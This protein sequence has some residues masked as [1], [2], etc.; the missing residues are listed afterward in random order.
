MTNDNFIDYSKISPQALDVEETLLGALML[1][2]DCFYEVSNI[3]K[4]EM[5]YKDSHQKIYNAIYELSDDFKPIDVLTVT[6]HLRKLDQLDQVGGVFYITNLISK[7]SSAANIEE[8]ALIINQK[9]LAREGI[10]ISSEINGKCYDDSIDISDVLD[11]AY[12]CFDKINDSTLHGRTRTFAENIQNSLD[13]YEKRVVDKEKGLQAYI[14][15]GIG[16]LNKILI[17]WKPGDLTI[18]AARPS[19]GKTALVLNFAKSAANYNVPIDIFSL[20]MISQQ[21]TDRMILGETNINPTMYQSGYKVDWNQLE[22]ATA[23]IQTYPISINDEMDI[24]INYIRSIVRKKYK[25][26]KLGLVIIDYLQ[27]MEGID[28][29]NKNNEVGS[30]TRNLKKLC[31][32]YEFPIIVLSQLSREYEKRGSKKHKLSDLRDSGNIEQDAD[33][34]IFLTRE[35]YDNEDNELDYTNEEN[36]KVFIDVAKHRNGA[37]GVIQIY[38][39]EYVNNFYEKTDHIESINDYIERKSKF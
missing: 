10:R 30:I 25:Q 11:Y 16:K 29:S 6:E 2:S 24:S 9:Y 19:V 13:K 1:E 36:R 12:Q 17:G 22:K 34:V 38:C 15:T 39:N 8:Y 26:K 21:I 18:L 23:K 31:V 20:E 3:L 5:F 4:S 28:K 14:T 37:L 32:K 35:R 33:N 27:L 7:I